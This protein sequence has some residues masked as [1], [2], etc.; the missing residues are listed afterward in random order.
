MVGRLSQSCRRSVVSERTF[1]QLL[2]A[3]GIVRLL[4]GDLVAAVAADEVRGIRQAGIKEDART[5]RIAVPRTVFVV[6]ERVDGARWI[7]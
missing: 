1:W 6:D 4:G 3:I 2:A 7:A 5:G